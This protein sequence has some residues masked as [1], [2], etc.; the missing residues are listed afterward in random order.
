MT[1]G[2]DSGTPPTR[3]LLAIGTADYTDPAYQESEQRR[4]EPDSLSQ[5]V[6]RSLSA[7]V[8]AFRRSR[9]QAKFPQGFLLN[10]STEPLCDILA[11]AASAGDIVIIYYTGHGDDFGRDGYYLITTD[12][13][14]PKRRKTGVKAAA[15]PGLVVKRR[16]DGE[17]DSQQPEILLILDCCFSGAGGL[18]VLRDAVL[19]GPGQKL[20]VWATA[21]KTQ[22]AT[23]GVF[24]QELADV[25]RRPRVGPSADH[26][27]L[28][29]VLD[30]IDQAL[31]GT[32]QRAQLFSP[33]APKFPHFFPNPEHVPH[34]AGRTVAEQHWISKARGGPETADTGAGFYLTGRTGRVNAAVDLAQWIT[35]PDAG[36]LA[37]L[38]GSPGTGKSA[39][40]SLPA[41]LTNPAGRKLLLTNTPQ[42]S[43]AHQ[44]ADVLPVEADVLAIHARGRSHESPSRYPTGT[45]CGVGAQLSCRR[46]TRDGGVGRW[47]AD[48]GPACP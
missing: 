6:R 27:P 40:L 1:A 7:V 34:V 14:K 22:Y 24:A 30:V 46:R 20:W 44:I 12:F 29:T 31:E 41:L 37:V 36:N 13:E 11:E 17:I 43:L 42:G 35:D 45:N 25:L 8:E 18:E 21:G 26:I 15:L 5:S 4:R 38:T 10:P 23:S 39:L 9:V 47:S 48:P 32:D 2:E 28:D 16:D 33:P 3:V 19:G